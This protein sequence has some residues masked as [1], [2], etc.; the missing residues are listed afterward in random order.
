MSNTSKKTVR[1]YMGTEGSYQEPFV[2]ST[3]A[4]FRHELQ[5][6]VISNKNIRENDG[7][8]KYKFQ[9]ESDLIDWLMDSDFHVIVGQGLH[10]GLIK[11]GMF[12]INKIYSEAVAKLYSH[13]G[14]PTGD[15]LR[16]PI[17]TGDKYSYL[18]CIEDFTLPTKKIP[19]DFS[20]YNKKEFDELYRELGR[21]VISHTLSFVTKICC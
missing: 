9:C 21:Y 15:Y 8:Y 11:P 20:A 14:F 12:Q 16:D 1:V 10:L 13:P 19:M 7:K 17:F 6:D 3:I 2:T 5:V 4:R 18:Q